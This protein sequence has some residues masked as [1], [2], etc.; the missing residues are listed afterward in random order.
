VGCGASGD[1]REEKAVEKEQR[2]R[3]KGGVL[4]C[5]RRRG[6]RS[7]SVCTERRQR[8]RRIPMPRE[9]ESGLVALSSL[10][11]LLVL[12]F[13]HEQCCLVLDYAM[14]CHVMHFNFRRT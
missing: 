2:K 6:R 10:H 3:R 7:L 4:L 5:I 9:R 1:I 14:C 8:W 12:W 11:D 13:I